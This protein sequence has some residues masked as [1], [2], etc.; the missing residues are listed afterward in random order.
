MTENWGID[1][2]EFMGS[3]VC[4]VCTCRPASMRVWI[5]LPL[6]YFRTPCYLH[7]LDVGPWQGPG[8][9][10]LLVVRRQQKADGTEEGGQ[11]WQTGQ[12]ASEEVLSTVGDNWG[13][14]LGNPLRLTKHS[15]SPENFPE[16]QMENVTL[17]STKPSFSLD[18]GYL[19]LLNPSCFRDM[20]GLPAKCSQHKTLHQDISVHSSCCYNT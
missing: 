6:Y 12:H 19:G 13:S 18:E 10:C 8:L 20:H 14:V 11:R 3:G 7:I 1:A 9:K 5:C 15:G 16:I 17:L 2:T 4:H